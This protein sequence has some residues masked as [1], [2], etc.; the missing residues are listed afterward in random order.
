MI[1]NERFILVI[2]ELKRHGFIRNH[3]EFQKNWS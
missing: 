1:E 3:S 2:E